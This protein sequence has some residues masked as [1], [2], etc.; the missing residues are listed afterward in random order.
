MNV[1]RILP[2]VAPVLGPLLRGAQRKR[3][4]QFDAAPPAPGHVV[5]L[6]DSISEQGDWE[7]LF[8]ELPTL[9][10]GIGGYAIRDLAAHLDASIREP[11]AIS[12]LIGTNDLH[13][14]GKSRKIQS[15]AEQMTSLVHHL[16]ALAPE[17]RLLINSVLPRTTHFRERIIEL[18]RRYRQ[19]AVESRA[20]YVDAWPALAGPDGAIQKAFTIEGLHLSIEGYRV[21]ADVL[22]PHLAVFAAAPARGAV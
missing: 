15:I 9:N 18:N 8:P 1:D 7:R 17:A 13:G 2:T 11:A 22:R 6:G 5:F 21:W 3:Q 4:A 19:I 12:L 16:R 10:R 20:T 14:L